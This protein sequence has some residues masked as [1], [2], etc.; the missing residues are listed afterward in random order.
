MV[1]ANV[2]R[3]AHKKK[4]IEIEREGLLPQMRRNVIRILAINHNA[5]KAALLQALSS[6]ASEG[7]QSKETSKWRHTYKTTV[8][9]KATAK[10][11]MP[12]VSEK[13]VR[14]SSSPR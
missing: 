5:Q 14:H 7:L 9:R 3:Y 12:N 6:G 1:F 4:A 13:M 11:D 8:V 10:P 2:G